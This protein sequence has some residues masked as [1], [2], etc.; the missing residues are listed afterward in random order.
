MKDKQGKET[1]ALSNQESSPKNQMQ[2]MRDLPPGTPDVMKSGR[3][4]S[5][6]AQSKRNV[7]GRS[8]EEEMLVLRIFL[9]K[10][11][12]IMAISQIQ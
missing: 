1:M 11:I 7:V 9:G 12:L 8:L 2:G 3:A 10:L 6:L 4:V 5:L